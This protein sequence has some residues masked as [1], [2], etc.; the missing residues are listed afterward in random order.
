MHASGTMRTL[1]F[2]NDRNKGFTLLEILIA[3]AILGTV[4]A[5]CYGTFSALTDHV[6]S[7]GKTAE[8]YQTARVTMDRMFLDLNNVYNK[9]TAT[10][11]TNPYS[12]IFEPF[13]KNGPWRRFTFASTAHMPLDFH[14]QGLDLCRVSYDLEKEEEKDTFMLYRVDDL[15]FGSKSG[16]GRSMPIGSGFRTFAVTFYDD[17]GR[18]TLMWDSSKGEQRSKLPSRIEVSFTL[19]DNSGKEYSF[20]SAWMMGLRS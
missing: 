6:E 16:V 1:Y 12:F 5:V 8:I 19:Q 4:M 17:E 13:E 3:L 2:T 14:E 18:P 7:A 9:D 15:L 10:D 20:S 11:E